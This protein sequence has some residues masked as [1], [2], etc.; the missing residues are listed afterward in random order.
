MNCPVYKL[1]MFCSQS[2]VVQPVIY[3]FLSNFA[4]VLSAVEEKQLDHVILSELMLQN[5]TFP[6]PGLFLLL[7]L[8]AEVI[9]QVMRPYSDRKENN[10]TFEV[11]L[12]NGMISALILKNGSVSPTGGI[13]K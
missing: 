13:L 2:P 4:F 11:C 1:A 7:F 12:R 8:K 9:L 6:R 10:F 5:L 3:S